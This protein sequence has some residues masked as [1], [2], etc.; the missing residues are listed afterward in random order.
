MRLHLQE[1]TGFCRL[2]PTRWIDEESTYFLD[3]SR[4]C[5]TK[6]P[7]CVWKKHLAVGVPDRRARG[8]L[9]ASGPPGRFLLLDETTSF[10]P[11]QF[12]TTICGRRNK[13]RVSTH[14]VKRFDPDATTAGEASPVSPVV[15]YVMCPARHPDP[16]QVLQVTASEFS[17]SRT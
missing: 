3:H 4:K 15:Q 17:I 11:R 2:V 9:S 1:Q 12:P 8:S 13:V 6:L 16:S 5:M 14:C 7:Q 10:V